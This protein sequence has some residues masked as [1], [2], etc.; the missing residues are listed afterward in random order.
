MVV[1]SLLSIPSNSASLPPPFVRMAL[2]ARRSPACAHVD[3]AHRS[4]VGNLSS[5]D[6]S[7]RA[8][9]ANIGDVSR[10]RWHLGRCVAGT[11]VTRSTLRVLAIGCSMTQGQMNCGGKLEGRQ[12]AR[13]CAKLRWATVLQRMLQ[14]L[15]LLSNPVHRGRARHRGDRED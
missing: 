5:L 10:L 12:C 11:S 9:R 15:P 7:H 13:P 6:V 2:A 3:D 8:A 14:A 4:L 1:P